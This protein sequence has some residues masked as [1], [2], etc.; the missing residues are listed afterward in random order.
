VANRR[1][2]G[3]EAAEIAR[4]LAD[5]IRAGDA[6]A[7]EE[8][9]A[10]YYRTTLA[11]ARHASRSFDAAEDA[12]QDAFRITLVRLRGPGLNRPEMLLEYLC[13]TAV[14]LLTAHYR[15]AERQQT[16]TAES[17]DLVIEDPAEDVLQQLIEQE[18]RARVVEALSRMRNARDRELLHRVYVAGENRETVR[19]DFALSELHFNRVLFRARQRLRDLLLPGRPR[20]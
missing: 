13:S 4:R 15:K 12:V 3:P 2:S 7:E 9:F 20:G 19:N 5:R 18:Q 11:A 16:T 14:R 10:R 1:E 6:G 17:S 8:L